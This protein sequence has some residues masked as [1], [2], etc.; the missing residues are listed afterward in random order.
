MKK[1]YII[2]LLFLTFSISYSQEFTGGVLLGICGSQIDGDEQ[3][4]YN[5]AGLVAGAFILK[6]LSEKASLKIETY[7]VGK[8]ATLNQEYADGTTIQ[9]FNTSLHYVEMPFLYNFKFHPRMDFSIGIA[10]SYL[11]AHK[12]T[13]RGYEINKSQY[14]LNSFDIQAMGQVGFFLTDRITSSLRMSYSLFNI[15]KEKDAS[16]YNNNIA[17]VLSYNFKK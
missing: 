17:F 6:P 11:F 10:P 14:S 16:W 4:P 12:I 13:R 5:K 8:G 9:I 15:R 7:Y 3:Y 2:I 1:Y